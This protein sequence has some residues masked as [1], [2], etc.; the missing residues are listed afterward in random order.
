VTLGGG[1]RERGS[2]AH[3]KRASSGKRCGKGVCA[4][5]LSSSSSNETLA[6]CA[7]N[8]CL[9]QCYCRRTRQVA[10]EKE[11]K[12]EGEEDAVHRAC[13]CCAYSSTFLFPVSALPS[14]FPY[15][16]RTAHARNRALSAFLNF[17]VRTLVVTPADNRKSRPS[18][19]LPPPLPA[20]LICKNVIAHAY[21]RPC[22]L[23]TVPPCICAPAVVY[24]G[25]PPALGLIH[26]STSDWR[27][28]QCP[29]TDISSIAAMR[30]PCPNKRRSSAN[31]HCPGPWLARAT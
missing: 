13:V 2:Q 26:P 7:I 5:K 9:V 19:L 11:G 25:Q 24:G 15:V 8:K 22:N 18:S 16:H 17:D 14:A 21:I 3:G 10:R 1:G 23:N 29:K 28:Q 31:G 27:A 20:T 6:R 30:C 4:S 12:R